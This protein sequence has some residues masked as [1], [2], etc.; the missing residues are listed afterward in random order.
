MN[1]NITGVNTKLY[2][3]RFQRDH[4]SKPNYKVNYVQCYYP[5]DKRNE[6][7]QKLEILDTAIIDV[8]L[9]DVD[10]DGW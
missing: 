5:A 7:K 8:D 10:N 9:T 2:H 3:K 4:E 1:I 6:L